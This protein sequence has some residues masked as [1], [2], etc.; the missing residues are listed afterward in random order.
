M[1]DI[2]SR[3]GFEIGTPKHLGLTVDFP[4]PQQRPNHSRL[5]TQTFPGL[6]TGAYPR[7]TPEALAHYTRQAKELIQQV[8]AEGHP[9]EYAALLEA[10]HDQVVRLTLPY[11]WAGFPCGGVAACSEVAGAELCMGFVPGLR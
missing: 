11:A 4:G 5:L 6:Q 1:F 10:G 3:L 8:A 9:A 2:G 7:P